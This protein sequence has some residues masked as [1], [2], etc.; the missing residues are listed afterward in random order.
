MFTNDINQLMVTTTIV[1]RNSLTETAN[2]S[3]QVVMQKIVGLVDCAVEIQ[4]LFFRNLTCLATL[5][6]DFECESYIHSFC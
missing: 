2:L 5:A 6:E 4:I 3:Y 1:Y